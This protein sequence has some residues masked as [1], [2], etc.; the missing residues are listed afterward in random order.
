M[1]LTI[2]GVLGLLMLFILLGVHL[3][4][5]LGTVSF[6]GVYWMMGSLDIGLSILSTTAYE[7]LRKDVFIIIPLFV[8]MGD[9]VSRSGSANDLYALCNRAFRRL[10]GCLG[11]ATVAGNAVFAAI[12]GVSIAAAA[13]FSRIA[14]PEM[15]ALGYNKRFSLGTVAGSA[16]LGM[17][18]PPSILMIVWAVLTEQSIGA[19]FIAGLI[20]GLILA[21]AFCGYCVIYAI[22]NPGC[23]PM[24]PAPSVTEADPAELR[25]QS[26]GGLAILGL[27]GVV[28]GGIWGGFLTPTEAAGF[29]TMGAFLL[30]L[31][32]GMTRHDVLE[33]IYSAG[34]TTAPIMILL[35]AASM[36][37]RFLAMGGAT[38]VI[39][40]LLLSV[41]ENP[42][43][44]LAIIF[45]VWVLL[46]M[47]ID[48]TSIILLT[49]PIFA[50]VATTLGVDPLS[51]AIF[52]IL[53][54][55]A[56]LLTP[57]FGILVFTVKAAVP[58]AGVTLGDIFR[59][60]IPFWILI[61]G[62][63]IMV[64]VWPELS[65]WLPYTFM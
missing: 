32:K 5:A 43:V 23:A 22:R 19:L 11:V 38:Q 48:S 52:G 31:A 15:V 13:T 55:E 36:Y 53:V 56:G 21:V 16:C 7:A 40:D 37:S 60:A 61:L 1:T 18:I 64:L 65:T 26:M 4:V 63:A 25:R 35:I 6:V 58:D 39:T 9:F 17:L 28:I 45:T 2:F 20:P 24:M 8:L 50:P 29:G 47:F 34:R 49:V 33:A 51:F 30:G 12:T 42:A 3:A 14:Y 57:P 62:V 59:G 27:I 10:P 41:S 46:G 44:V 54:I